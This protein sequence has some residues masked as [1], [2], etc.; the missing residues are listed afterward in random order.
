MKLT[1]HNNLS[2]KTILVT[3]CKMWMYSLAWT[4]KN[5]PI[6]QVPYQRHISFPLST[7]TKLKPKPMVYN[8]YY[9][10]REEEREA[11]FGLA[12]PNLG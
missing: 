10:K 12:N 8:K 6:P 7:P 4:L 5:T 3:L 9:P 11:K 1:Y 2:M